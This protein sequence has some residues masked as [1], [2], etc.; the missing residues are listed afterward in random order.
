VATPPLTTT[1]SGFVNGET[2]SALAGSPSL[3]T[4]A[5]TSSHPGAYPITATQGTLA[6]TNYAFT[7]IGGT[8]TVTK[9][10]VTV[11]VSNVSRKSALS[12]G[13]LTFSA[14][15]THASTGNA[16]PGVPVTFSA[17]TLL[18]R[19]QAC[20][21]VTTSAGVAT[22]SVP[23]WNP[24]LLTIATPVTAA[25]ATTVDTLPGSGSASVVK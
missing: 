14:K 11:A 23:V 8:L 10:P 17:W 5:T 2:R 7:F 6:S 18:G 13:K 15:V 16:V 25:A 19:T 12:S 4:T 21:A 1:Y 22:C 24:Q 20:S 9:A 3:T